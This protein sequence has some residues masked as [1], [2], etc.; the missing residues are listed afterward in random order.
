MNNKDTASMKKPLL[1]NIVDNFYENINRLEA[2]VE[3]ISIKVV[4]IA[5]T[6]EK[7]TDEI[8]KEIA[9]EAKSIYNKLRIGNR[10]FTNLNNKLD[11]INTQLIK[12]IE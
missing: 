1:N 6:R 12:I 4:N 5:D 11:D 3:N 2:T 7:A 8:K 9:D 10:T